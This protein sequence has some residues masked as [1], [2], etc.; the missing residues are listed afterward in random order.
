MGSV[1]FLV[2]RESGRRYI[3]SLDARDWHVPRVYSLST[4]AIG[5]CPGYILSQRAQLDR[6]PGIF[7]LDARVCDWLV[8]RVYSLLTCAIGSGARPQVVLRRQHALHA[9]GRAPGGGG[10][11]GMG[12]G[13]RPLGG[14]V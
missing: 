14:P 4:R 12:G 13:L 5:S 7:S 10:G 11:S 9:A 3:L 1:E 6:A 2:D 8:P